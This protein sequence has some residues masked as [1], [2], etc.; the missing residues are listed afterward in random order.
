MPGSLNAIGEFYFLRLEGVPITLRRE[1]VPVVRP[2]VDGV[3][4]YR[5]GYRGRPFQLRSTV[6]VWNGADGALAL[7]NYQAAILSAPLPLVYGNQFFDE[8]GCR[9]VV[10]DVE[11][12][13]LREVLG[14]VGGLNPPSTA[15]VSAVWTLF[16]VAFS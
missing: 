5:T 7:A 12:V 1:G 16:P 3:A 15:I 9:Y 11:P 13:E 6:D 4:F 14:A 2:G 10:M 8:F